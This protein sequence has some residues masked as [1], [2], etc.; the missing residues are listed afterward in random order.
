MIKR[1]VLSIVPLFSILLASTGASAQTDTNQLNQNPLEPQWKIEEVTDGSVPAEIVPDEREAAE[2]GLPDGRVTTGTGDIDAAWYSEPTT[3][4]AHGV[5]GDAIEAGALKVKNARQETFT[6]RL[7]SNE[8]FEDI[9]PRLA[10]LDRDGRT[11]VITML[12]SRSAG[13]SIAVFHLNGNAFIKIAQTPFIGRSNRWLNVAEIDHF[14]GN[15]RPDIAAVITPH[16]AGVLQ[17]YRFRNGRLALLA[18]AG[19]FSNHFIGSNELRLSAVADFNKN[20]IPD[21][22]I[23]SLSRNELVIVGM[24]ENQFAELDRVEL[25]ARVNRAIKVNEEEDKLEIIVGLDDGKIYTVYKD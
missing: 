14:G 4:Y 25:P 12:S 16:L 6:I 23:P 2:N 8:V 21:L 7:D 15:R 24:R 22:I 19:G 17:F 18:Q 5:L 20:G 10:D 1:L 13:A 9:S 3:R 11:E